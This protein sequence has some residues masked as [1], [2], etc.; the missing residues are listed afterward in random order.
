MRKLLK[1]ILF[2]VALV[3]GI[4]LL[5]QPVFSKASA[6]LCPPADVSHMFKSAEYEATGWTVGDVF[7]LADVTVTITQT[8]GYTDFVLP[9][10]DSYVGVGYGYWFMQGSTGCTEIELQEGL[11]N[12]TLVWCTAMGSGQESMS[13]TATAATSN[14]AETIA[15]DFNTA[16]VAACDPNG[17][18][19]N[20]TA[21]KTAWDEAATNY[22]KLDDTEKAKFVTGSEDN[23]ATMLPKYDFI[24]GKYGTTL[25]LDNFLSR[26]KT[27]GG[28]NRMASVDNGTAASLAIITVS[29]AAVAAG[30]VLLFKKRKQLN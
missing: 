17:V 23:I 29:T 1:P 19:S 11:N 25:E 7:T 22:A 27:S 14:T 30:W 2:G 6:Q 28:A 18:T 5:S 13:V 20:T 3:G 15:T 16:M 9:A 10:S 4:G 8:P 21:I 12:F 26:P 24:Y